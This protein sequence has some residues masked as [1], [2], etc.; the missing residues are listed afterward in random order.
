[1]DSDILF[2]CF[3]VDLENKRGEKREWRKKNEK[4]VPGVIR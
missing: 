2:V 4:S 1:M 3:Q